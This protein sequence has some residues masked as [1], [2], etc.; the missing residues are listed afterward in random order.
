MYGLMDQNVLL[1]DY[2]RTIIAY[3]KVNK[4]MLQTTVYTQQHFIYHEI[5]RKTPAP[6]DNSLILRKLSISPFI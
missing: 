5:S 6:I 3:I 2:L 1:K 4:A